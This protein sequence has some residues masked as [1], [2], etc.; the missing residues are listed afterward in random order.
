V[1]SAATWMFLFSSLAKQNL[2]DKR[3]T[4]QDEMRDQTDE[5]P[6]SYSA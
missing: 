6:P 2:I 5:H 4:D 1:I 3:G